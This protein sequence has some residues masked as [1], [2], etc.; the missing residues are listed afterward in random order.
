VARKIAIGR[1]S[2]RLS[3][4]RFDIGSPVSTDR[5]SSPQGRV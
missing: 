2:F 5:F 3:P 4:V 1:Y